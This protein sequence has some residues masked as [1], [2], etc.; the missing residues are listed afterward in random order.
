MS[1]CY[2]A[3]RLCRS[4]AQLTDIAEF[5]STEVV[6]LLGELQMLDECKS[7]DNRELA[8]VYITQ[9]LLGKQAA[10]PP[11]LEVIRK[12]ATRLSLDEN[13][14]GVREKY[15]ECVK[16]LSPLLGRRW[17]RFAMLE[18]CQIPLPKGYDEKTYNRD[19]LATAAYLGNLELVEELGAQDDCSDVTLKELL[20]H[21]HTAAAMGGDWVIIETLLNQIEASGVNEYG[22]D[23]TVFSRV[24]PCACEYAPPRTVERLIASKW[25][26]TLKK[27]IYKF[28]NLLRHEATMP[29]IPSVEVFKMVEP[30]I[31]GAMT[32]RYRRMQL[33]TLLWR[34]A[35]EGWDDMTAHLLKM[36]VPVGGYIHGYPHEYTTSTKPPLDIASRKTRE[37]S[38]RLL[39]EHH[40]EMNG[41]EIGRVSYYG[42]LGLVKMLLEFGANVDGDAQLRPIV[43][44]VYTEH[45]EM[46]RLLVEHGAVL[47]GEVGDSAVQ[48]AKKEGLDS[49]LALLQEHGVKM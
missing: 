16:A 24:F 22:I 6:Y 47:T 5:F 20:P 23:H 31:E 26:T 18:W 11:R 10:I 40:A 36:E 49:M 4:L 39:L 42:R 43:N 25:C 19:L 44:A 12:I 14:V 37:G 21:P 9:R 3:Q 46:F 35:R 34:A 45:E 30:F 28:S 41:Q 7:V 1:A 32:E 17:G 33:G 29:G 13:G 2:I 8:T 27:D 15:A 38:V 48:V